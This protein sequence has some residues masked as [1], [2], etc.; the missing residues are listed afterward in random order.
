MK[1]AMTIAGCLMGLVLPLALS[2]DQH[3]TV[4]PPAIPFA[5]TS[6]PSLK[7]P[8]NPTKNFRVDF[9]RVEEIFPLSR[10]DLW[11]LTPENL[12]VLS[13]EHIDQIYGRL[14]AGPIPAGVF[15]SDLFL[16]HGDSIRDRLEEIVGGVHGRLVGNLVD[17]L[18]MTIG[19][20]WKDKLFDPD[21][22]VV[23]TAVEDLAPLRALIDSPDTL[24][25]M[26]I[27][28]RGPLHLIF[29]TNTVWVLFP[30][31]LYC[32]QSLLDGRRESWIIDYNYN[33]DIEGYRHNPDRILGRGGLALRDE[34]RI[35]RPGFYL[36]RAYVGRM[37]LLNFTLYDPQ[38]VERDSPGFVS[39]KALTEPCWAGE[40][41]SRMSRPP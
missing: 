21:R 5:P 25:T 30:A 9:A 8:D 4:V 19:F 13:Q 38:V 33:D 27:P 41:I 10:A 23:R 29:P 1:A 34:I 6:N 2:C 17:A 31:K 32:G 3:R 7:D 18:M 11:K 35:V 16:A 37:F 15:R 22:R 20:V 28:R 26:T 24:T 14:S 12:A 36:G 39:G 40:Q